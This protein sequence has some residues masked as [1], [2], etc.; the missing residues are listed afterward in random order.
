M[1]QRE[2]TEGLVAVVAAVRA[3]VTHQRVRHVTGAVSAGERRRKWRQ[4]GGTRLRKRPHSA[5][6]LDVTGQEGVGEM[7]SRANEMVAWNIEFAHLG[8][9]NR[10]VRLDGT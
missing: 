9:A 6:A 1:T 7:L 10:E 4:S 2:T 3:M 8:E 5:C